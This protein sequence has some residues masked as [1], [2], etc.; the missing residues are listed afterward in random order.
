MTYMQTPQPGI[1]VKCV[2]DNV[3]VWQVRLSEF[4][5]DS[6][7][8]KDLTQLQSIYNYSFVE[9]EIRFM[10]DLYP[11]F[12]PSVRLVRPRMKVRTHDTREAR[13]VASPLV[14][15]RGDESLIGVRFCCC[16]RTS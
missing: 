11:F 16:L 5:P 8:H 14:C 2:D 10:M 7:M 6:Q 4:P 13:R 9:L 12:P 1:S 3:F 15:D